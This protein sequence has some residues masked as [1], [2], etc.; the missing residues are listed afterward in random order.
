MKNKIES[1]H[2][3]HHAALRRRQALG[4]QHRRRQLRRR[5]V[6][7][8]RRH[9]VPVH[10]HGLPRCARRRSGSRPEPQPPAADPPRQ[11]PAGH[12]RVHPGQRRR[13]RSSG[14]HRRRGCGP[15]G[16]L[17]A[18]WS[19]WPRSTPTRSTTSSHR[20]RGHASPAPVRSPSEGR[21]ATPPPASSPAPAT[22]SPFSTRR[23]SAVRAVRS[24][25]ATTRWPP[26]PIAIE[27]VNGQPVSSGGP[28]GSGTETQQVDGHR[29][30][31]RPD[32]LHHQ[33]PPSRAPPSPS[34]TSTRMPTV[35][36]AARLAGVPDRAVRRRRQ[37]RLGARPG[38]H[39][40]L[41]RRFLDR[42]AR[43]TVQTVSPSAGYFTASAGTFYF[44]GGDVYQVA[45]GGN[46][47]K[48]ITIRRSTQ[49]LT[50]G[51]VLEHRVLPGRPVRSSASSPTPL[52]HH[53]PQRL[54]RRGQ[55][56]PRVL[57]AHQP[58]RRHLSGLRG[59]RS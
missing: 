48:G 39:G 24:P 52:R 1:E 14:G 31:R 6:R 5:P 3:R 35:S 32:H 29:Q 21:A 45:L 55:R 20:H 49:L 11:G 36:S 7:H 13:H 16:V 18:R 30:R 25:S 43:Q 19:P 57:D 22:S 27:T 46:D 40:Q 15:V 28:A 34:S 8:G 4:H 41:R 38:G 42:S 59:Q 12:R 33:T 56:R 51:D 58:A 26:L 50:P 17:D 10:R 23:W 53:E 37:D 54:L 47:A 2:G 9:G 44:S